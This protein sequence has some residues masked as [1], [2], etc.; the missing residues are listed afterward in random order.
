[1]ETRFATCTF[2]DGGCALRADISD[3]GAVRLSPAD[4]SFPA[5]CAKAH[6]LDEYR[7]HPDRIV[8]PLKNVGRRGEPVWTRVSWDEALDEIAARLRAVIDEHGPEAVAFAETPLNM[9]FGGITRRL[10]NLIGAPNYTAPTQLCMGNT[11]QVHRAVYGWLAASDWA[12]ADCIVYFGQ[13]RDAERWPQEFLKLKAALARGAKLIVVD[14]RRSK[15]AELADFHLPIRYGTDAALALGWLN[16]IIGERLYDERFVAEQCIGFEDLRTR[17]AEYP[18]E[19]VAAIC[20]ID[21]ELIRRTARVYAGAERAIIPWGATCDMQANSTSVLLAQ[22]ALRAVCGYLN[23]S[24]TVFGPSAGG[25]RCNA[26]VARYD[27]LAPDQR[28][29]QLGADAHPLLTF[30]A[31]RLYDEA[32]AA[33]GV[34]YTPDI[35]AESCACV[36][37]ALFA[38]MRSEGPYPVKAVIVAANNTVMSYAG[39][40]GIIEGFMNQDLVVAFENWMTPTAQL[41][42][43][44]LPGDMWAE[45][46]VLGSPYD[47]APLFT[48]SQAIHDPVAEC[49]SWFFVVRGL[50]QRL[51]FADEFPWEDERAYFDWRLEGTGL[52]WNEACAAAPKPILRRPAAPGCFITPSGKV[53]LRSSVLEALEFDPLPSYAKPADPGAAAAEPGIYPYTLFAG[54]R[55]GKS[56]N[57]CLRQIASLRKDN[58]EPLVLINP[59]DAA[60]ESI[61]GGDQCEV[62][63]AYGSVRLIARLDPAQPQGTLRVPHGWWKPETAPGL[64]A[65]LSCAN[66]HNDGMLFPDVDWNLDPAQGLPNLRGGIHGRI[67]KLER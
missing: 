23:V 53:E 15:T 35:L 38:A 63:S 32:N 19:R 43:F 41:A 46:D 40:P 4:P 67:R 10:M 55:E 52:T 8:H 14:P 17:A 20:G 27:R 30:R 33:L 49:K 36:P 39:Q 65:G 13:D 44:V 28:A 54:L 62:A 25:G 31:A 34:D 11:A 16:V 29:K 60:T 42:D 66:L 64:A 18:P 7:L 26:Q 3:D 56:Y 59:A 12:R 9:G 48:V 45:R 50:A 21:A 37:P 51:G 47:M 6:L 57:T 24:E 22:C 58:P 61:E 5:I 2:C 1:M